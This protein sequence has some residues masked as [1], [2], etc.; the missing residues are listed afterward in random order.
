MNRVS[1]LAAAILCLGIVACERTDLIE[2]LNN[3]LMVQKVSFSVDSLIIDNEGGI[4]TKTMISPTDYSIPWMPKDTIGVF[5][6]CGSQVYFVVPVDAAA[7]SASFDG[8]GWEFKIGAVYRGYYPFVG[9]I[10]LDPKSVPVRYKGQKQVGNNNS[11]N[12]GP[13]LATYTSGVSAEAGNLSFAFHHLNTFLRPVV[14]LPAGE[15]TKMTIATDADL[16]VESGSFDLTSESPVIV[17]DK[18][19]NKMTMDLDITFSQSETM[20]LF[21]S[22]APANFTGHE[23]QITIDSKDGSYSYT[24]SPSKEY[25]SGH[26]YRLLASSVVFV[27]KNGLVE[28]SDDNFKAYCVDNFDT[29]DDGEISMDEASVVT[30][31]NVNT[32]NITSL[33]GIEHFTNLETLW[34]GG[35]WENMEIARGQLT[36]LNISNNKALKDLWC[37]YNQLCD[38]DISNNVLLTRVVL[39]VN[40]L[41]SLDVRNNKELKTLFCRYGEA[42]SSLYIGENTAL[43]SLDC[44]INQLSHLDVTGCPSLTYL[45]CGSNLLNEID[46]SNNTDLKELRCGS[47]R[48]SAINVSNNTLLETLNCQYNQLSAISISNN[49]RLKDFR[50]DGNSITTLDV[51]SLEVLTRLWCQDNNLSSLDVSGNTELESLNCSGNPLGSLILSN[52]AGLKQL[53]CEKALLTNINVADCPLLEELYCSNNSLEA[54]DVSANTSLR[55]L[56]CGNNTIS[57]LD[58]SHNN[59]LMILLCNNNCLTELDVSQNKQLTTL[60]CLGNPDFRTLYVSAGQYVDLFSLPDNTSII[61]I[62]N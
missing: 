36:S 45:C 42:L 51:S 16:F 2:V 17:A 31:I 9:D 25:E 5:P 8:G 40:P 49:T 28:F 33:A 32:D 21:V 23:L 58:V 34:C 46:V 7:G 60:N 18:Y 61:T 4:M 27:P 1:Y 14:V 30:K 37:P 53:A 19:S 59:A 44:S 56:Q 12:I 39:D 48:L 13:Y 29:N 3:P 6:D 41:T 43:T 62:S 47:N 50:C 38:L 15:Y 54:L 10:Y 52:N 55:R 26:I 22:C 24:Y 20:T 35:T 57:T 11:N